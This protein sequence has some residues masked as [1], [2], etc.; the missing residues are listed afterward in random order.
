[1]RLYELA[2]K[3]SFWNLTEH[4]GI[5]DEV[6]NYHDLMLPWINDNREKSVNGLIRRKSFRLISKIKVYFKHILKQRD[7]V[8]KITTPE[9]FE[10]SL[11]SMIKVW[12]GGPGDFDP[13]YEFNTNRRWLSFTASRIR[14][15]TFSVYSGTVATHT[16]MLSKNE[17]YWI[18]EL[19]IK[20]DD[21]LG[22]MWAGYD[23]EIIVPA[24]YISQAKLIKQT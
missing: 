7:H 19:D 14:A 22:Y 16:F 2:K 20:L 3:Y 8:K 9:Q 17:K 4:Y 23:D 13:G 10:K 1:M 5:K 11:N 15:D 24:S 18:V 21:I 12:R 6:S